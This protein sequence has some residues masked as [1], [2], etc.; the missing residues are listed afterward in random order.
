[1]TVTEVQRLRPA[2]GPHRGL[3]RRRVHGG[4]RA[5]GP[6]R[7]R[8][9]TTP[10]S[11]EGRRRRRRGRP[12]RQ[13]R[14]RQGLGHA[15]RDRSS[16]SAPAS[17]APTR[18][19]RPD[20]VRSARRQWSGDA[21]R[22]GRRHRLATGCR[23]GWSR[24]RQCRADSTADVAARRRWST[25]T[26]LAGRARAHRGDAAPVAGVALVAVGGLGRRECAPHADLDLSCCTAAAR[27]VRPGR[28]RVWYPVWDA[29]VGLDHSVRTA[30]RRSV[31]Q[32][33]SRP[34]S[35]CSTPPP[36]RRPAQPPAAGRRPAA[37]RTGTAAAARAAEP[38][39]PA[40]A[41]AS[42]R[43]CWRPTSRRPAAACA[44]CRLLDALARRSSPTRPGRAA[45]G[46]GGTACSTPATRCTGWPAAPATGCVRRTPT[47]SAPRCGRATAR[48]ARAVATPAARSLRGRRR[49]ARGRQ[50]ARRARA[51]R[52][53]RRRAPAR[54]PLAEAWSS[55]PA[56]WCWP[57][58]PSPVPI[59]RWRC[60]SPRPP[61]GTGLP[62]AARHLDRLARLC[63]AAA[64]AV[65]GRRSATCSCCSARPRRWS[66]W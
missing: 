42:S 25:S 7:G 32:E 38:R 16:G 52:R 56:R 14:R 33:T 45:A 27:R 39:P 15:G 66:T 4:L 1:M 29:G 60:G 53:L 10:T 64:R 51:C 22:R 44:T 5:E 50:L 37:W 30:P 9:S 3:P 13:D 40:G 21:R 17:A 41:T 61:P 54:R 57:A 49:P 26:T 20:G 65:A 48:P 55:R 36:G 8:S 19:D 12:H 23:A 47:R 6:G 24:S 11:D 28:R 62:F 63:A 34:P 58:T 46:A 43:S 2:E 35:A 59:R 18:S 31:A